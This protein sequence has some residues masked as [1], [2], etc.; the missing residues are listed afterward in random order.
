M[1][2]A[3]LS[4][5][6]LEAELRAIGA[7]RYHNLHPFHRALHDGRLNRG[8]VQAWAL[9]RYYYQASIPAKD[10]TL[11]ARLPTAALRREWRR[12]LE[13]HDGDAPGTGG[14]ARWLHLTDGLGL[15]RAYVESLE[16]LLPGTRFAVEAYVHF[17]RD[18]TVLAAIASSLTELFSPTIISERVS[19]MLRNYDFI[20]QDTLAYFTPRLTQAPRDSDF[21]LAYVKE[22]ART[23]EQQRAVL[24]ALKFKC[25]VL[26]S[27]LDALDYAYVTP[28][29]I[30]PGAFRP[31]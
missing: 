29:N 19:G 5:E 15:D 11:L 22:H 6:S 3:L 21:A 20:T 18:R 9:N 23:V 25:G 17:V 16:G 8:Q 30:P 27:M 1:R 24:G 2:D 7:E 31:S 26:W 14:V 12:R 4:P 13:D 28:G 10:A